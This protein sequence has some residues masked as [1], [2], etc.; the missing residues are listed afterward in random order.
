MFS[1]ASGIEPIR[2]KNGVRNSHGTTP[3]CK[4]I[5]PVYAVYIYTVLVFLFLFQQPV[6]L[7][8]NVLFM[9]FLHMHIIFITGER[10]ALH[11]GCCGPSWM[12]KTSVFSSGS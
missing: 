3:H 6:T 8:I 4:V 9:R 2:N 1:A 11:A 12:M 10:V 7:L 5:L